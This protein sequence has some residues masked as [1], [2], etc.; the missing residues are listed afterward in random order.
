MYSPFFSCLQFYLTFS[1]VL[2]PTTHLVITSFLFL[3]FYHHQKTFLCII[4][5]LYYWTIY[6][7]NVK[8]K[9]PE[10]QIIWNITRISDPFS[11]HNKDTYFHENKVGGIKKIKRYRKFILFFLNLFILMSIVDIKMTKEMT[12]F[13]TA[14][15]IKRNFVFS[16]E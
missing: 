13:S 11:Y 15:N 14:K 12:L 4:P 2:L 16:H 1:S 3:Q 5:L 8:N 7:C 6:L 9:M 10:T